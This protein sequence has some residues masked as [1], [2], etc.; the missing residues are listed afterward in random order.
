MKRLMKKDVYLT[1]KKCIKWN[2]V[3]EILIPRTID[4]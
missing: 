4:Y 3:D 1:P 2:I